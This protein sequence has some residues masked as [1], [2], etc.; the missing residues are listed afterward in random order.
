MIRMNKQMNIPEMQRV[1]MEF[2][3]QSEIMDMKEELMSEVAHP[4]LH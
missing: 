4:Q 2:E 1:M 3:K